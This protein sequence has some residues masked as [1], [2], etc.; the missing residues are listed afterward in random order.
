N[1]NGHDPCRRSRVGRS[2]N[3]N[4]RESAP[5]QAYLRI[6]GVAH[7]IDGD[8]SFFR[9]VLIPSPDARTARVPPRVYYR[10]DSKY[11]RTAAFTGTIG[12]YMPMDLGGIN[13]CHRPDGCPQPAVSTEA[14]RS[15][16]T[17]PQTEGPVCAGRVDE[18]GPC[19]VRAQG[20]ARGDVLL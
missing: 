17:S 3:W 2:H 10:R 18:S 5:L 7:S 4:R 20:H 1:Q 14:N 11:R 12:S 9:D 16:Q 19:P 6:S 8:F 15:A 13:V